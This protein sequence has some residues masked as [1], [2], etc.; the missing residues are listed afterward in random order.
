M[1]HSSVFFFHA[2]VFLLSHL[3]FADSALQNPSPSSHGYQSI[4]IDI[5]QNP[6]EHNNKKTN[7]HLAPDLI[8]RKY[9]HIHLVSTHNS[10]AVSLKWWIVHRHF[11]FVDSIVLFAQ[12]IQFDLCVR[13]IT[14]DRLYRFIQFFFK[15]HF[16]FDVLI[17]VIRFCCYYW[18]S[19][20]HNFLIPMD[21]LHLSCTCIFC[22]LVPKKK[23]NA[24]LAFW[25][26]RQKYSQNIFANRA[27][28]QPISIR[29]IR[30]ASFGSI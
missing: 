5:I 11:G 30:S 27:R 14:L 8:T 28:H 9:M 1:A 19:L 6:I 29:Q 21:F 25:V 7:V 22:H 10:R 3:S 16:R 2:I 26:H 13:F 20:Y 4:W 24:R 12:F 17:Y 18:F 15:N 23:K